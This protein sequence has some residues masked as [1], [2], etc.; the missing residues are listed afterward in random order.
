M[1]LSDR[2]R[3]LF[4]DAAACFSDGT[5]P[6]HDRWLGDRKVTLDE[7]LGLSELIGFALLSFAR[8]DEDEVAEAFVRGMAEDAGTGKV[9]AARYR[10]HVAMKA[11]GR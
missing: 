4:E 11:L 5:S 7:C 6:F 2:M 8:M 3:S 10:A 9:M 1:I